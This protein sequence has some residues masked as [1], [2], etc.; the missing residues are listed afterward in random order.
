[1][2]LWGYLIMTIGEKIRKFR[3]EK[4]MTQK[5]LGEKCG[6]ADSAIRRYELGGANPK[7]ETIIKIAKALDIDFLE[8]IDDYDPEY[9]YLKIDRSYKGKK[10]LDQIK[11]R[12]FEESIN[13]LIEDQINFKLQAFFLILSEYGYKFEINNG[14]YSVT[15][16]ELHSDISKK[17]LEDICN[18]TTEFAKYLVD[19]ATGM[20]LLKAFEK[21][22]SI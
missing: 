1:M 2:F 17:T 15:C 14:K 6:L 22:D 9:A 11:K 10:N 16:G 20:R 13:D 21:K 3:L 8:L 4:E 19:N 18:K 7:F 12:N 5:E